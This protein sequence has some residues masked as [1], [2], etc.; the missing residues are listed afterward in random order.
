MCCSV[1]FVY[2]HTHC[3][4][5]LGHNWFWKVCMQQ[6]YKFITT[7][8]GVLLSM[9]INITTTAKGAELSDID[10]WEDVLSCKTELQKSS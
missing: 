7:K 3:S 6:W 8:G 1:M 9:N 2:V 5:V 4:V 10:I